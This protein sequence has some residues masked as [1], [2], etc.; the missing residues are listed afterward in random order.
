MSA[1]ELGS[2]CSLGDLYEVASAG[3]KVA[4]GAAAKKRLSASRKAMLEYVA[5]AGAVYGVNTG[6]GELA[7][8]RI[9]GDK[10]G[11]LQLNLIRSHACGV[12][13]PFTD[14]QARGLMFLRANE[15][16]RCHSGVCPEVVEMLAGCLNAGII[17]YIPSRG[18]VGAS[19]DL[20]PSAHAALTLLGEGKAKLAGG[21]WTDAGRLLAKAG[22]R[23]L[24]LE[25]KEGLALIN[26]TQAM[27][28]VGGLALVQALLLWQA[29]TAAAAMSCEA[30]KATPAPFEDAIIL[31]KPHAGQVEA[32]RMLSRLMEGSEIRKS[33]LA[34]DARVQDSYSIRCSPQVHG[35]VRDALEHA[36]TVLETEMLSATDNPLVVWKRD[37]DFA[38]LE[39]RS[40]G[41][42]H[43]QPLSLAFDYACA[44]MTSLGNIC[45]RRLFQLVSDPARILPPFLAKNSG[46]ESGWMIT[47]YTAAS[48]ASENKTLAHPASSDSIPTSGNK[49]DFVSMGM[50]AAHKLGTVT[51]NT[52]AIAAIE[53]LAGA[54][55]LEFHKPLKPGRGVC[56]I[57][58]R[59]RKLAPAL[60][61]DAPLT[62]AIETVQS[63]VL[64]GVFALDL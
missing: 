11:Q 20:A 49:E 38:G 18:S 62:D 23:P 58:A 63:A 64:D 24:K 59:V 19:G 28:S 46:L 44:A 33:H 39:V 10:C 26:G 40:G 43:G 57:Y 9:P 36:V 8:R 53:L 27:Q 3:R 5:K 4:L 25:A 32:G 16:A 34:N 1:F 60:E 29:A 47:Q 50:W 17:P 7:S 56:E 2:E 54:Q 41:N 61:C 55:G 30:L 42:F 6:F 35:A 21:E 12:G 37:S 48:L 15:L 14:A 22:L 51:Q 52:A 13:A 31:L 45:E